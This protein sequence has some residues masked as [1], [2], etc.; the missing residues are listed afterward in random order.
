MTTVILP[1]DRLPTSTTTTT[2]PTLHLGPGLYL[3]IP[4]SSNDKG[5]ARAD[6][7]DDDEEPPVR[8]HKAGL[9]G[10]LAGKEKVGSSGK[11]KGAGTTT[12]G[13]RWWVE[14]KAMRVRSPLFFRSVPSFIHLLFL[15]IPF[16]SLLPISPRRTLQPANAFPSLPSSSSPTQLQLQYVAHPPEPI[17]GIITAR[18]AEGYR[19]DIG[20]SSSASLDALAFE[21][22][23]KRSKPNLKV[24][25]S[26]PSLLPSSSSSSFP[27]LFF[28]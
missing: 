20:T 8:A 22:A 17:I 15:Y 10:H 9:L 28:F 3:P 21:G 26:V 1:G 5:K 7:D 27:F 23:T 24:P 11:T 19:V 18:H 16:R 6:D 25:R 14:G 12:T 2:S 13:E 4:T